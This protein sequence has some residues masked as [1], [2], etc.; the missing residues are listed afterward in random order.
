MEGFSA[1]DGEGYT[2]DEDVYNHG[3]YPLPPALSRCLRLWASIIE[4]GNEEKE[5]TA[6]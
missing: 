3:K 2:P 1:G 5:G 6:E 4:R